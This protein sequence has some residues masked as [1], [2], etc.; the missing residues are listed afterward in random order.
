MAYRESSGGSR[1]RPNARRRVSVESEGI[2]RRITDMFTPKAKD[3]HGKI[4]ISKGTPDYQ[5]LMVVCLLLAFGLIML[6]SA[7]SFRAFAS[8]GDSLWFLKR[9][10][11]GVIGGAVLM[12][13]FYKIDYHELARYSSSI[14][15]VCLVMLIM[16]IIPGVGTTR[17]GATRW[18]F[19]LQPSEFAK[20]G[21]I[22][23][24]AHTL[25][26]NRDLIG[27]FLHGYVPH[28]AV[29][30]IFAGLL[31]LEPHFSCVVLMGLTAV[32]I[33]YVAGAK[34]KHFVLTG[35][36]AVPVGIIA[37]IQEPYRLARITSFLD[38]FADK[39]GSGWQIVQSLYAIGSG[40]IFGAGLGKSSQKYLS[41]P[42][43]QNDFIFSVLA[44]ELG[45]IGVLMLV[46]LFAFLV[47][48]GIK[49]A[50]NAPDMFGTLL[51]VGIVGMIAFQT[52][53]NIAVVTS[54]V[55]VT[56]MPLPFF[57]FGSSALITTMAEMGVVMSVSKNSKS[58]L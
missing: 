58:L 14:M 23:S 12:Y 10:I 5:F 2:I 24:F 32:L 46:A 19:S 51:V 16:V 47:Y 15:F 37:I 33:M 34:I 50:A 11:R 54:T 53:I 6:F 17:N 35:L 49:I 56:G 9:Q 4:R 55:P 29:L 45:L 43:P 13:L 42:E 3:I 36:M 52:V 21:I 28:I 44:E 30:G 40:G 26:K 57:S 25:S 8:T 31:M 1:P 48:R 7:G 39:Q 18:L 41:L 27:D 20:F 38:P 22:V